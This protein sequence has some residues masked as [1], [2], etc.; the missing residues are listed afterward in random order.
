[1]RSW[2]HGAVLFVM[3]VVI[4][5]PG[6]VLVYRLF[7]DVHLPF[8]GGWRID[9]I[10]VFMVLLVA[11]LLLLR[12]FGNVV[13]ALLLLGAVAISIT[14]LTGVYG[15]R[16]LREDYLVMLHSLRENTLR[17]P[18]STAELK[19][20]SGAEEIRTC[21]D[22]QDKGVRAFAV[23]AAT[24]WFTDAPVEENE[25]TLVQCFS[26][27][28]TINSAW[29]YVSDPKGGEYFAKASESTDL[30]AG[31]C[32]DHAILMAACIKAI[33][34]EA[35]LVRTTGHIYPEMRIGDAQAMDRAAFLIRRMLFPEIAKH[36][37]LFYHVDSNGDRW[38]NMDY[39]RHYPG[40]E[41][42][43]EDIKGVLPV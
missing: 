29:I 33:G 8:Q 9:H 36:A 10:L 39:T 31:D 32:D 4:A 2:F 40:G 42:M 18:I 28:K 11:V 20:F 3:A 15:F 38:I 34:G 14:G 23:R 21:I 26:I 12:R 16:D 27:F 5:L 17:A 37:T 35:R 19:P 41:V 25:F 43:N 22:Y 1:V 30:L 6:M 24:S 7:P 13:Y